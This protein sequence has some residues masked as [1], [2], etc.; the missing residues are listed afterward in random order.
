MTSGFALRIAVLTLVGTLGMAAC[1]YAVGR[2]DLDPT[3]DPTNAVRRVI[4]QQLDA[5]K[6]DDAERAFALASPT[7]RRAFRDADTF[8]ALIAKDYMPITKWQAATFLD[9]R[10]AEGH[11]VQRVKLVDSR[12]VASVASYA[13]IKADTGDWWVAGLVIEDK[14]KPRR[15]E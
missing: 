9:M 13:I 4:S 10:N 2:T 14:D 7:I 3:T 5:F 8:M 15:V 11:Y 1:A 12:G 6:Q